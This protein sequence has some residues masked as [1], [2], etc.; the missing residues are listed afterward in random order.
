MSEVDHCLSG[1]HQLS[2]SHL[3]SPAIDEDRLLSEYL[4][5]S[6]LHF[7]DFAGRF[8]FRLKSVAN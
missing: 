2:I 8:A 1:S 4:A 3:P 7:L 6:S 5:C